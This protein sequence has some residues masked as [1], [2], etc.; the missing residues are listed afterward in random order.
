MLH[1]IFQIDN[2]W[3]TIFFACMHGLSCYFCSNIII[4]LFE[5][6]YCQIQEV[7]SIESSQN[8]KIRYEIQQHV[9][10]H[11]HFLMLLMIWGSYIINICHRKEEEN[12]VFW[13]V[14]KSLWRWIQAHIIDIILISILKVASSDHCTFIHH[15][16][17]TPNNGAVKLYVP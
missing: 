13:I 1:N 5:N 11:I 10:L 17:R 12:K 3:T 9:Y 14:N 6:N 4:L 7:P 15:D 16:N 2:L 8:I